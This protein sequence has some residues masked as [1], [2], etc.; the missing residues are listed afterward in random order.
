MIRNTLCHVLPRG[1][2]I[3]A[4]PQSLIEG[5]AVDLFSMEWVNSEALRL[6]IDQAQVNLPSPIALSQHSKR[7][8]YC[9]IKPC[10]VFTRRSSRPRSMLRATCGDPHRLRA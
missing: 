5:A 2:G 10:H 6:V 3:S 8:V 4:V 1:A 7:V 9:D